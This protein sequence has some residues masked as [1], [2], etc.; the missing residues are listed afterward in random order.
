M[1]LETHNIVVVFMS[2][3]DFVILLS[4]TLCLC[5]TP[6]PVLLS[7]STY[8][9]PAQSEIA[10]LRSSVSCVSPRLRERA[11]QTYLVKRQHLLRR[12]CQSIT[13]LTHV[14]H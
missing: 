5:S 1:Y 6:T 10:S 2:N 4:N 9:T 14:F 8:P 3:M 11:R 12:V 13:Q 7:C